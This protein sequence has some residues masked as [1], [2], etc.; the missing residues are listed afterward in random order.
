MHSDKSTRQNLLMKEGSLFVLFC[1][2]KIHQ[3]GMLQIMFFVPLENSQGGGVHQLSFIMV[4][5][6]ACRSSRMIFSLIYVNKHDMNK[7]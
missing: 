1:T 4:F 6:L 5:G 3:I 2:N 7:H